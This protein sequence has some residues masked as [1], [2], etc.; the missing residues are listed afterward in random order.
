[1]LANIQAHLP[2]IMMR[3]PG[4]AANAAANN[5]VSPKKATLPSPHSK[6]LTRRTLQYEA[7][8]PGPQ[9]VPENLCELRSILAEIVEA[10]NRSPFV[11]PRTRQRLCNLLARLD[12]LCG[13]IVT[14]TGLAQRAAG[15]SASVLLSRI[16][17]FEAL[18]DRIRQISTLRERFVES[19]ET[20]RK[21]P[22]RLLAG[23]IR[24]GKFSPYEKKNFLLWLTT[25]VFHS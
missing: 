25:P 6:K 3:G 10:A 16:R 17:F 24:A 21:K 2:S 19:R 20:F 9:P 4:A 7:L 13:Q 5:V 12:A 15:E 11:Q 23:S 22:T 8:S 1:M 14:L 18:D